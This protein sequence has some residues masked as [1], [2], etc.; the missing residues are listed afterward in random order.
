[1]L[2]EHQRLQSE[3]SAAVVE[4]L[5]AHLGQAYAFQNA[6]KKA[7]ETYEELLAYAQRQRQFTLASM[8][9]NRLAILAVQQANDKAQAHVLLE[10]AL[11]MAQTSQDQRA[12]AE[13]EWN[14]A[15]ITTAA[16]QDPTSAL[17]HGQQALSLARAIHDQELEARSLSSLGWSHLLR[18]DF[19]EAIHALDAAIALYAA[20]GTE[21]TASQE[22][23]IA[24]ALSDA[25]PP[26]RHHHN[27]QTLSFHPLPAFLIGAPLTQPL[28]NRASEAIC[29]AL[30][31]FTQLNSGQVHDSIRSGRRALALAQ[32]SKSVWVQILSTTYL[33]RGLL[34]AGAYEEA[35]ELMQ[36]TRALVQT[37]PQG[38][39]L[40][41]FLTSLGSVYHAMQQWDEAGRTLAEAE[42]VAERLDFGLFHVSALSRLCMHY[43]EAGEWAA[44]Y[45]FVLK[46]ISLRKGTEVA[47]VA[48]DFFPQYETEALLRGG[49]ERQARTE[50]QR[51]GERLGRYQR[52]RIP[53][54]RSLAVL[55]TWEGQ[56]EQAISS[57][58]EAAGLATDLG[59][60]AEQWQIQAA[61][62][63]VYEAGGEPVQAHRAWAKAS[64]IIQG[65]AQ[66]IRDEPLRT[67]FLA[68]PQIQPVLQQVQ[69][70]TSQGSHDHQEQTEQ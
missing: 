46:A 41:R 3:L 18:G 12:L 14:L 39:I 7:Q 35:L 43:A 60:P 11:H 45:R 13:T 16:W 65:L 10:R 24:H 1:L 31:A 27:H 59:L 56:S 54:L 69:G 15:Q 8:T 32:E 62:A 49:D 52:F 26:P 33:A 25:P 44:A 4:R 17:P 48:L 34:E 21:L 22:F 28:T 30:L 38:I 53:Y 51:L 68:G 29:W 37:L 57:L 5:Y 6:W 64:T 42:A 19:E 20:L 47:L 70:E 55:S 66:G 36:H 67:R 50:V 61:L 9:L 63:R 23:S 40:H 2:Q 58:L